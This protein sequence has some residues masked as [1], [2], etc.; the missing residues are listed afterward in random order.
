M[1]ANITVVLNDKPGQLARLGEATGGAGVN[2]LGMCAMTGEG[3]GVI[4]VLVEESDRARSAIE[5]AGLGVADVREALV[6]DVEDRPGSIGELT[7][8]L[9]EA[10]VNIELIYST[11]SGTRVAILTDDMASAHQALA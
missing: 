7:R 9:A 6:V 8:E 4:N 1:A 3:T 10:G 2:L 5:A 11:F